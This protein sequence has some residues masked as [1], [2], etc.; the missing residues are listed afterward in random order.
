MKYLMSAVALTIALS[1]P[2][3]AAPLI[4]YVVAVVN[5]D[6]GRWNYALDDA[7]TREAVIGAEYKACCWTGRVAW[8]RYIANTRGEFNTSLY[9]QLE[10]TGLSR[11]GAG[12][13]EFLPE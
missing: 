2:A 5:E 11:I 12:I 10:L 7:S 6:V 1:T 13:R 4:D 8:R 9:L 3:R